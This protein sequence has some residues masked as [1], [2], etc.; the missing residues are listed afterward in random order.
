MPLVVRLRT[1]GNFV[2]RRFRFEQLENEIFVTGVDFVDFQG[3]ILRIVE[4]KNLFERRIERHDEIF[5]RIDAKRIESA[6]ALDLKTTDKIEVTERNHS[7]DSRNG[8]G[9]F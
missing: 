3:N 8:L 4:I 2:L 7:R 5:D 6:D 1:F 9:S